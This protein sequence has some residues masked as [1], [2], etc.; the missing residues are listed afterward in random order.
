E[1]LWVVLF[2][3]LGFCSTAAATEVLR[4]KNGSP[5]RLLIGRHREL[6]V[7]VKAAAD[8]WHVALSKNIVGMALAE[9]GDVTP[10]SPPSKWTLRVIDNALQLDAAR[11]NAD[12]VYRVE[13]HQGRVPL[14]TVLVY[15][16][17][18]TTHGPSRIKFDPET[19]KAVTKS[20]AASEKDGIA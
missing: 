10:G 9:G 12:H 6:G 7:G 16:Y 1:K 13:L 11:F 3:L 19:E 15:L 14:G 18:V 5:V 17:P 20:A 4:I 2:L 8:G